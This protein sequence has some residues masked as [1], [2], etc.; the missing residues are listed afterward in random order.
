MDLCQHKLTMIS[1]IYIK[2]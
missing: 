1:C 2:N